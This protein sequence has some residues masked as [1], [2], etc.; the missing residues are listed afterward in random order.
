MERPLNEI[1]DYVCW[2]YRMSKEMVISK[3]QKRD[4]VRARDMIL[5]LA[6]LGR[7]EDIAE[8]LGRTR[9]TQVNHRK[10]LYGYLRF[11]KN[12]QSEYDKMKTDLRYFEV[13]RPLSAIRL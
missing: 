13:G 2:H 8:L 12:L 1:L 11:N 6:G 10:K 9:V 7:D 5:L 3:S 4:I